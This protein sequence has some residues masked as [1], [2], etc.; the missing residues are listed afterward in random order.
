[1]T[2]ALYVLAGWITLDA[3]VVILLIRA[4]DAKEHR[5]FRIED[6]ADQRKSDWLREIAIPAQFDDFHAGR[7]PHNMG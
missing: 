5:R 3:I 1:M 7:V 6:G 2:L 4:A